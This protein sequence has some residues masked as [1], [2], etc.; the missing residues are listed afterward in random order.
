MS[1][2]Q[3]FIV[4]LIAA[5]II[6]AV[7]SLAGLI[8]SV[9]L[10]VLVVAFGIWLYKRYKYNKNSHDDNVTYS[11]STNGRKKARDVSTNDIDDK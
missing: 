6:S 2:F 7:L 11:S 8:F 1:F 5:I 4:V 3:I 9:L 10:P